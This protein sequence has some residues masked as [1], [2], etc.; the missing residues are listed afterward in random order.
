MIRLFQEFLKWLF[1]IY[2][3]AFQTWPTYKIENNKLVYLLIKIKQ[4]HLLS[5]CDGPI[6]SRKRKKRNHWLNIQRLCVLINDE[7]KHCG[8]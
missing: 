3:V 5:L 4:T 2:I 7:T 8:S 1:T 6:L